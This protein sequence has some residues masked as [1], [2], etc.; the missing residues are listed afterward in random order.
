MLFDHMTK[1][2]KHKKTYLYPTDVLHKTKV[3]REGKE[4]LGLKNRKPSKLNRRM[5]VKGEVEFQLWSLKPI[6]NSFTFIPEIF[7]FENL[8][9]E[10]RRDFWEL[11]EKPLDCLTLLA[12]SSSAADAGPP[13]AHASTQM[14]R[15]LSPLHAFQTWSAQTRQNVIGCRRRRLS[16]PSGHMGKTPLLMSAWFYRLEVAFKDA[17][18]STSRQEG[19]GPKACG[20]SGRG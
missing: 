8:M 9:G 18:T 16:K 14:P 7:S 2:N 4:S 1:K 3:I 15:P 10:F 20:H 19:A 13:S 11:W 17:Q 6:L 5:K 12:A